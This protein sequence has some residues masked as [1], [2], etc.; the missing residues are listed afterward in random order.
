MNI[1][2]SDKTLIAL[3]RYIQQELMLPQEDDEGDIKIVSI[4]SI[5]PLQVIEQ[6]IKSILVRNNYGI[7]P[8]SGLKPPAAVCVWRWEVQ[9]NHKDWLP[10]SVR[11]KL[12]A[13]LTE[14]LQVRQLSFKAFSRSQSCNF[15]LGQRVTEASI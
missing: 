1:F 9:Q 5:L 3:T 12:E 4:N 14:R 10:K 2:D 7:E 13:R 15:T 8:S 11:E 6:A